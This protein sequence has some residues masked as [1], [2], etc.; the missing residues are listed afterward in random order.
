LRREERYK[1]ITI[2][3]V[4]HTKLSH[5]LPFLSILFMSCTAMKKEEDVRQN[6]RTVPEVGVLCDRPGRNEQTFVR[7]CELASVL[8]ANMS[9]VLPLRRPYKRGR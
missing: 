5:L 9:T 4:I 1:A 7:G 2:G 6:R 8:F 3:D